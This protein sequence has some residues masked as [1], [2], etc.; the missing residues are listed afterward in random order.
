[1]GGLYAFVFKTCLWRVVLGRG[2]CFF[3][4][5]RGSRDL[6]RLLPLSLKSIMKCTHSVSFWGKSSGKDLTC[7][8]PPAE[9]VSYGSQLNSHAVNKI[10][11][12]GGGGINSAE[13]LQFDQAAV[14]FPG[15][16]L[17]FFRRQKALGLL[18]SRLN[19]CCFYCS[20]TQIKRTEPF[21]NCLTCTSWGIYLRREAKGKLKIKLNFAVLFYNNIVM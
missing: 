3:P 7:C 9:A 10:F 14:A 16:V 4:F 6:C 21:K 11:S 2:E 17:K 12:C 18:S 1:M 19:V 13:E 8:K 15:P 5:S 20:P